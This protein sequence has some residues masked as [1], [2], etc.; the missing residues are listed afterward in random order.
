MRN[1]T[2]LSHKNEQ[3]TGVGATKKFA[4]KQKNREEVVMNASWLV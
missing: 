1:K 2:G 4:S 3:P